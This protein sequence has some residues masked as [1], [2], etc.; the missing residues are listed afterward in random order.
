MKMMCN[1]SRDAVTGCLRADA[2]DEKQ[3]PAQGK[4]TPEASPP[5]IRAGPF[6]QKIWRVLLQFVACFL[7]SNN[8][9]GRLY[10]LKCF[11]FFYFSR[12]LNSEPGKLH[13]QILC[14][15]INVITPSPHNAFTDCMAY[16]S[17]L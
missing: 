8:F 17:M 3:A 9:C 12:S 7:Q 16:P 6:S 1:D 14:H 5:R 10:T 2:G 13:A 15:D 11:Q 4:H